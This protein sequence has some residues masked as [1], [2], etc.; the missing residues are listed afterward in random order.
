MQKQIGTIQIKRSFPEML[1]GGVICD[2]VNAE[3]ARIAEDAGASAVMALER[4][5]ADLRGFDW[6]YLWQQMHRDQA[7]LL[8]H[9]GMV[10][11]V[12]LTPDAST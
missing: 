7:T 8:G 12:A 2:V 4:V 11:S 10:V 6:Y 5:P 9:R 1:K 3:Q